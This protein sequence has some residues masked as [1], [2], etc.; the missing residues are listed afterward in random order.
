MCSCYVGETRKK[1]FATSLNFC[2]LR[3]FDLI[4]NQKK[5]LISRI[6]KF[7][8]RHWVENDFVCQMQGDV[9]LLANLSARI[10]IKDAQE[11]LRNISKCWAGIPITRTSKHL[12]PVK[13]KKSSDFSAFRFSSHANL[14]NEWARNPRAE[15]RIWGEKGG[16][17]ESQNLSRFHFK[18]RQAWRFIRI[19]FNLLTTGSK[20]EFHESFLWTKRKFWNKLKRNVWYQK[21]GTS[22]AACF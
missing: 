18:E 7:R 17:E 13:R 12:R 11:L 6:Q 16:N 19:F 14:S 5:L 2:S 9:L 20:I 15:R 1:L 21:Y 10:A 3:S 8:C 4:Q 22:W